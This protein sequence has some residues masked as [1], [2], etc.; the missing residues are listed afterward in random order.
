MSNICSLTSCKFIHY[1]CLPLMFLIP[2]CSQDTNVLQFELMHQ[3]APHGCVSI[4]GD[5]DQSSESESLYSTWSHFLIAFPTV[6][7]WRS[8]ETANLATMITSERDQKSS[9]SQFNLILEC[10]LPHDR[11]FS[12]RTTGRCRSRGCMHIFDLQ[13]YIVRSTTPI[14]ALSSSII[15]QG[16]TAGTE[17]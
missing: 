4:V 1:G 8:A 9:N 14:L 13:R 11:C 6:Y 15:A 16:S 7:G 3:M 17:S 2:L 10:F 5:P 12:K